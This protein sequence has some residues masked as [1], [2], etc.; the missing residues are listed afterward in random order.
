MQTCLI[1]E[2]VD[3]G[4]AQLSRM[5]LLCKKQNSVPASKGLPNDMTKTRET[6]IWTKLK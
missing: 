1:L 3:D 2:I 6:N 4:W 5:Q